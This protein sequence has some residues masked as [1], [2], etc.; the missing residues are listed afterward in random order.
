MGRFSWQRVRSSRV[1]GSRSIS[2]SESD[3]GVKPF[4]FDV[5]SAG[6]PASPTRLDVA[7]YPAYQI[8]HRAV[9][10]PPLNGPTILEVI[11]PP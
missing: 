9:P 6:E 8:H 7:I 1:R 4:V 10:G 5:V 2:P 3:K 11:Q